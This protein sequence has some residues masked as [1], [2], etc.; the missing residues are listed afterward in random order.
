MAGGHEAIPAIVA[1]PAEHQGRAARPAP[2]RRLGDRFAGV[3]H[4]L[5]AGSPAGD[6]RC[7]GGPHL[8]RAQQGVAVGL[9]VG[10][11]GHGA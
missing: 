10:R 3:F 8:G 2:E 1:G 6:G 5:D 11:P 9:P 4:E 7:I